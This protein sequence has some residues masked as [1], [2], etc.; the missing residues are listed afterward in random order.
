AAVNAI[1]VGMPSAVSSSVTPKLAIAS[2]NI[3]N[4]ALLTVGGNKGIT[5]GCMQQEASGQVVAVR[6]CIATKTLSSQVLPQFK[7]VV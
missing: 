6:L 7:A 3:P 4:H 1:G 5:T 2:Q